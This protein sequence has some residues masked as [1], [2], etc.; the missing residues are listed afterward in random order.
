VRAPEKS[1]PPVIPIDASHTRALADVAVAAL[2]NHPLARWLVPVGQEREET[3]RAYLTLLIASAPLGHT[4]DSV[5]AVA[6]WTIHNR[7]RTDTPPAAATPLA[8]HAVTEDACRAVLV[9]A[10]GTFTERFELLVRAVGAAHQEGTAVFGERYDHL[11]LLAVHPDEKG[12]GAVTALLGRRHFALDRTDTPAC[13]EAIDER[14]RAVLAAYGYLDYGSVLALPDGGP[15]L[16]PMWR[17][18]GRRTVI[19]D[20]GA[21][22]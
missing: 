19:A 5:N 17:P 9:D 6:L 2:V 18:A 15:R 13:T 12:T 21:Q 14:T 11:A 20:C 7:P 8:A 16:Y 1:G 22:G 10:T 3:L 4:T